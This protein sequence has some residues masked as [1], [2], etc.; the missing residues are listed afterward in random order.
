VAVEAWAIDHGAARE[1]F[2]AAMIALPLLGLWF[3]QGLRVRDAWQLADGV[4][5]EHR[6]H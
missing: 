5:D 2:V 4:H 3:G 6:A 1:V